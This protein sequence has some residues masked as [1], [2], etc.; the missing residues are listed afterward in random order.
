MEKNDNF[1]LVNVNEF[2]IVITAILCD[3]FLIWKKYTV[4][5][6]IIHRKKGNYIDINGCIRLKCKTMRNAKGTF[7]K[8]N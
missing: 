6:C 8:Q 7:L 2:V 3:F 4:K 1:L 5:K